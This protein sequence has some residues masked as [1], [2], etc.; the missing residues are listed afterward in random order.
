MVAYAK[1]GP[2][3]GTVWPILISVSVAPGSYFFCADACDADSAAATAAAVARYKIPFLM[4]L[5]PS[6]EPMPTVLQR[7]PVQA[8][9]DA[10]VGKI[11]EERL[12]QC[13]TTSG[14]LTDLTPARA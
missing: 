1:A 9:M 8:L 11:L 12:W 6:Y 7:T 14:K 4:S 3:N 10:I 5:V 2:R 13:K